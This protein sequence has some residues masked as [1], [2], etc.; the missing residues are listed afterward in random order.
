ME[1]NKFAFEVKVILGLESVRPLGR[2]GDDF[3]EKTE[4]IIT[5]TKGWVG[6]KP[7]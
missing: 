4:T 3:K 1:T 5:W 2:P 7:K 6:G